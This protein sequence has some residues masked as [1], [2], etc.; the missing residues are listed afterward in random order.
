LV[1]A[2]VFKYMDASICA[3]GDGPGIVKSLSP[4]AISGDMFHSQHTK[5]GVM[6]ESIED[7]IKRGRAVGCDVFIASFVAVFI[8][9][10]QWERIFSYSW[11]V[12][13][14]DTHAVFP[15]NSV[16]MLAPQITGRVHRP[17][18]WPPFVEYSDGICPYSD[19]LLEVLSAIS[20]L[21]WSRYSAYVHR[22]CPSYVFKVYP[23]GP[24]QGVLK[25]QGI[26]FVQDNTLL[27]AVET[28][29]DFYQ[30]QVAYFLPAGLELHI[31][32]AEVLTGRPYTLRPRVLY[33]L[34]RRSAHIS[35]FRDKVLH[36]DG[37]RFYFIHPWVEARCI[38]G[39]VFTDKKYVMVSSDNEVSI[40][41]TRRNERKVYVDSSFRGSFMETPPSVAAFVADLSMYHRR[42]RDKV[43]RYIYS[44]SVRFHDLFEPY[45]TLL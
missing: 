36:Y 10:K 35:L 28:F 3:P 6:K 9:P 30:H 33:A 4:D 37:D 29:S 25:R 18:R 12:V 21:T 7:T 43:L 11:E 15:H 26:P 1:Q 22:M 32:R 8:T 23:G 19:N 39:V 31:P 2:V 45:L 38:P 20:W 17:D 13:I 16:E 24:I 42:E 34:D 40:I 44:S 27:V 5:K 14:I 41:Y